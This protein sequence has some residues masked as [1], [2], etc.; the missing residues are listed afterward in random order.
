[1]AELGDI[2]KLTIA[3]GAVVLLG[4]IV[5]GFY[6]TV[7]SAPGQ[8]FLVGGFEQFAASFY[9]FISAPFIGFANWI[10]NFFSH[11]FGLSVLPLLLKWGLL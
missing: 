8:A 6:F 3:V 9:Q 7:V 10:K 11:P 5:A 1:M 4:L 2:I